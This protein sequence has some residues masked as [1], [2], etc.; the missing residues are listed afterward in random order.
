VVH[1]PESSRLWA[2]QRRD[3]LAE[4]SIVTT[5][6]VAGS[7]EMLRNAAELVLGPAPG[8]P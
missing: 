8:A 5:M 6:L 3:D 7:P 1:G 4:E 2:L